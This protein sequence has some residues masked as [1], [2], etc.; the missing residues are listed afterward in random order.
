MSLRI[1]IKQR[2]GA[3]DLEVDISAPPGVTV[4]FGPSGAGK[5]ALLNAVAGLTR[6]DHGQIITAN[7]RV[8]FDSA[9]GLCLP[10]QRRRLGVIFQQPR[11]FP[12]LTVLQN[13]GYGRRFARR[14]APQD[15]VLPKFDDVVAMLGIGHLLHR[16]PHA[17][18]GGEGARVAIGRALLSGPEMILADE[19]LA[20]LDGARRAEI[21]PYFQ[22]LRDAMQIPMIYVTH[23]HHEVASLGTY[24]VAMQAGR[25]VAMGTPAQVLGRSD[26]DGGALAIVP[27]RLVQAHEDGLCEYTSDFGTIWVPA[28]KNPA[29]SQTTH[30]RIY[31]QDVMLARS[32]PKDISALNILQGMIARIEPTA[33][34]L[35]LVTLTA[36]TGAQILAR[37]TQRSAQSMALMRGLTLFAIV[38]SVALSP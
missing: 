21:L 16:R 25:A 28:Q 35:V 1:A 19:P 26:A 2:L 7:G 8:V 4:L 12:H 29:L 23:A 6:P 22:N 32:R 10:P 11:L 38:K 36:G 20:A 33:D 18:S 27:A 15:A 34:G 9:Q 24:V 30:L 17:L 3:F 31:A 5:T 13:L 37:I 14:F